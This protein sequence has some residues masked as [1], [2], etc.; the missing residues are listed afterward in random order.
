MSTLTLR[1]RRLLPNHSETCPRCSATE[2]HLNRAV[3]LLKRA[4]SPLGVSVRVYKEALSLEEFRRNPLESNRLWI[5]ERPLEE[6]IG[7]RVGESECCDICAPEACRTIVWGGIAYSEIPTELIL[8][9]GLLAAAHLFGTAPAEPEPTG[10][11]A[12]CPAETFCCS[13]E[14]QECCPVRC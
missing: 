4:L 10:A 1:W 8:R 5:Q 3:D 11:E 14:P 2:R 9:A 12:C 13:E 7:A 6:W